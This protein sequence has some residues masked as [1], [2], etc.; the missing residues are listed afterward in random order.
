MAD[1]I[2]R[3]IEEILAKLD[4]QLPDPA[5]ATHGSEPV[6]ISSARKQRK[7]TER[8]RPGLRA[9]VNRLNPPLLMFA[10][11]GTMI[12]GLLAASVAAALI[13][14]A[15]AGVALFLGAF[16]VSFLRSST[17]GAPRGGSGGR[18]QGKFWR[19]RYIVDGRPSSNPATRIKKRFWR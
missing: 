10:G 2:E 3:E 15:F 13:W 16:L 12:F 17:A 14:L 8:P 4:N 1:R 5:P 11:A 7:R 19:D 6:S 9:L 18:E